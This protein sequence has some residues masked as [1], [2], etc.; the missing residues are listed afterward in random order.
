MRHNVSPFSGSIG[1]S[2]GTQMY[3]PYDPNRDFSKRH[4]IGKR[5]IIFDLLDALLSLAKLRKR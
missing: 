2:C 5:L 3:I 4:T 1:T